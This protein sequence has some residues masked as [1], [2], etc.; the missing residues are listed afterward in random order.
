M[1]LLYQKFQDKLLMS[2][3]SMQ[4]N[5]EPYFWKELKIIM[6]FFIYNIAEFIRI[7]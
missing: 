4:I 1:L 7:K 5:I 2:M 6:V 3:P